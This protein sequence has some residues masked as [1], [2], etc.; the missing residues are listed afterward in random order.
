MVGCLKKEG[1]VP[2]EGGW[3]GWLKIEDVVGW[4][5]EDGVVEWSKIED[6]VF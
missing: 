2:E 6:G 5:K 3:V 1:G 4:P